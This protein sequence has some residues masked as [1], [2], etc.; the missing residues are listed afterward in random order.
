MYVYMCIETLSF[1]ECSP[2]LNA[3]FGGFV[4]VYKSLRQQ[5][6]FVRLQNLATCG[7]AHLIHPN[8]K[9]ASKLSNECQTRQ[10]GNKCA[11]V[12]MLK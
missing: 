10:D 1:E 9:D 3:Y 5:W 4:V 11:N 2:S 8:F 12:S 6:V 7:L